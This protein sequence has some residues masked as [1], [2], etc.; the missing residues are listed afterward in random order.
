MSGSAFPSASRLLRVCAFTLGGLAVCAVVAV[1]AIRLLLFPALSQRAGTVSE[2]L[3]RALDQRVEVGA[4]AG[5]WAGAR[6]VVDLTDVRVAAPDGT[7]GAALPDIEAT[8]SWR[9]L[10]L[11]R[12]SLK[13]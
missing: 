5:R 7:E 2:A 12:P 13:A 8:L 9:S 10:L 11:G 1:I 4:I 3:S 6:I